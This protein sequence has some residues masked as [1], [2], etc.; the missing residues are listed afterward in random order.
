MAAWA[1]SNDPILTRNAVGTLARQVTT[2]NSSVAIVA[3]AEGLRALV[4]AL[5]SSDAQAQCYA[6][7]AV[8]MRT[9]P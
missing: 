8:G 7:K 6:A 9:V 3:E 5:R 1:A 4:L 2:E